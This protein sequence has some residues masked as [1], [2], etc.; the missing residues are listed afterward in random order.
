MLPATGATELQQAAAV[1]KTNIKCKETSSQLINFCKSEIN[2]AAKFCDN[3]ERLLVKSRTELSDHAQSACDS[4]IQVNND[5]DRYQRRL[6]YGY[7]R[8]YGGR[9]LDADQFLE[10]GMFRGGNTLQSLKIDGETIPYAYEKKDF[11]WI[12][13]KR[14]NEE[15]I[16][17]W[18]G[19]AY[20]LPSVANISREEDFARHPTS[21]EIRNEVARSFTSVLEHEASE[22]AEM[23][24]LNSK[25]HCEQL[26]AKAWSNYRKEISEKNARCGA[27]FQEKL[28]VC[29]AKI[30]AA[31][32]KCAPT[33][34]DKLLS[35]GKDYALTFAGSMTKSLGIETVRQILTH[36]LLAHGYSR[37]T[38]NLVNQGITLALLC[39]NGDAVIFIARNFVRPILRF[40][41][42]SDDHINTVDSIFINLQTVAH[43]YPFTAKAVVGFFVNT[44]GSYVG[45]KVAQYFCHSVLKAYFTNDFCDRLRK[46]NYDVTMSDIDTAAVTICPITH[47]IISEPVKIAGDTTNAIFE[48][49]AIALWQSMPEGG[50]HPLTNGNIRS[51]KLIT[52]KDTEKVLTKNEDFVIQKECEAEDRK[53]K[54]A[55]VAG[56]VVGR[57]NIL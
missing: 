56:N 26:K 3:A 50:R 46:I 47:G 55:S 8:Q 18:K 57:C 38:T 29:R 28:D 14:E 9:Y 31:E 44:A 27:F 6:I 41:G 5:I 16:C 43:Y 40:A 11:D 37:I 52:D 19:K 30:V 25:W 24:R 2:A 20:Y 32:K 39:W 53:V 33:F 7:G 35:E 15:S 48:K 12:A 10:V 13:N 36:T 51:K 21:E 4:Y 17:L 1:S 54:K 23:R 22:G 42:V 34:S 45:S 49:A